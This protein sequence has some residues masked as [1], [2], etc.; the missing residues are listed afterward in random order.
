MFIDDFSNALFKDKEFA[1]IL[2]KLK[3]NHDVFI[4]DEKACSAI[5]LASL[6]TKLKKSTLI[7][8]PSLSEAIDLHGYLLSFLPKEKLCL[9]KNLNSLPWD[10]TKEQPQ[11]VASKIYAYHAILNTDKLV[12]TS[13]SALLELS[14]LN[15]SYFN[16]AFIL[17][18]KNLVYD[19]SNNKLIDLKSFEQKLCSIGYVKSDFIEKCGYFKRLGDSLDIYEAYTNRVFRIS[20]FDDE[21]ESIRSV[22]PSSGQ[23][24]SE[25]DKIEIWPA[26][27]LNYNASAILKIE[28]KLKDEISTN[29][30]ISEDFEKIKSGIN[31]ERE[32]IYEPFSCKKMH[33]IVDYCPEASL[34]IFLQPKQ[35]FDELNRA[36]DNILESYK[37]NKLDIAE[38]DD[39]FLR[40][41][42]VN[43]SKNQRIT[44]S[45]LSQSSIPPD[46]KIELIYPKLHP[47]DDKNIFAI[48]E[49]YDKKFLTYISVDNY[50]QL[51]NLKRDLGKL[52]INYLESLDSLDDIHIE[53]RFLPTGSADVQ[54]IDDDEQS[55]SVKAHSP[56]IIIDNLIEKSFALKSPKIAF[57]SLKDKFIKSQ[58]EQDPSYHNQDKKTL[59]M[60]TV[61]FDFKPGD[62]VVHRKHGIALFEQIV[63]KDFGDS[64]KDYMLLIY[65]GGDKLYV[66]VEQIDKITKYVGSD[67]KAPKLT[68]LG[69]KQWS[70]A[71][72]RAHSSAK[73]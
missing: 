23:T 40:P 39:Y 59:D 6:Y 9:L 63:R 7:I 31:F 37:D 17:E 27:S 20:F 57:I 14:C 46:I 50:A 35:I 54:V 41:N 47:A 60:T 34:V 21:I 62:Y 32:R 13:A 8:V 52:N 24:I 18:S 29:K 3:A 26:S 72:K 56:V 61:T 36:Y 45:N 67:A 55:K 12:I 73:K 53:S 48:K 28:H 22:L 2:K 69:S 19:T 68:S 42:M 5:I 38:L 16:P 58:D 64:E 33:S 70:K 11:N 15:K 30:Q 44:F 25:L 4:K 65:D 43:F 71:M 10:D 51:S 1:S 66:P 49:F